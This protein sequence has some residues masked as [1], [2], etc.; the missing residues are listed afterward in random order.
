MK[1]IDPVYIHEHCQLFQPDIV[2][3]SRES[4]A[5]D[6]C[7][8]AGDDKKVAVW[9]AWAWKERTQATILATGSADALASSTYAG[10]AMC[11]KPSTID[12]RVGNSFPKGT[13]SAGDDKRVA[14]WD[15]WAWKERSQAKLFAKGSAD[16]LASS[17]RAGAATG[18]E[19]SILVISG[20]R[21]A[22]WGL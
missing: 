7:C 22:V 17:M 4:A 1:S 6:K 15:A 21:A 3:V 8:L 19:H 5:I 10:A 2:M 9:D 12:I 16:A 18:S 14:V 20:E 11:P 13:C